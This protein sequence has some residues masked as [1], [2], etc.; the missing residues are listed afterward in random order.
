MKSNTKDPPATQFKDGG[1]R[2]KFRT[3]AQRDTRAGK[4]RFDLL[5]AD[6]IMQLARVMETGCEKYGNR[7]W[8]SGIPMHLYLDSA[9]RHIHSYLAGKQDEPHLSMAMWNLACCIQTEV[10]TRQGRY[11]FCI[12]EEMPHPVR[13][14]ETDDLQQWGD[15]GPKKEKDQA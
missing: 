5:P 11:D 8:E 6:A 2:T 4:G 15:D 10:W 1:D 12:R 9:M 3:G 13:L 7:N 14:L